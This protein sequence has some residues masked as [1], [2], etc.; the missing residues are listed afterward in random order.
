M[1]IVDKFKALS[2]ESRF[3]IYQMLLRKNLAVEDIADV[4]KLKPITVR[5]HISELERSG[6]ITK[7]NLRIGFAGR[8]KIVYGVN[9]GALDI[10]LTGKNYLEL[11][12]TFFNSVDKYFK[13]KS[14]ITD[15]YVFLGRQLARNFLKDFENS[16]ISSWGLNQIKEEI[17]CKGLQNY[18]PQPEMIEEDDKHFTFRIY[19]CPF[20]ETSL[21]LFE[22]ICNKLSS[23]YVP[24][25]ARLIGAVTLEALHR[26]T[27]TEPYCE[28]KVSFNQ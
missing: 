24:E 10:S 2:C 13:G 9:P 4:T 19:S 8:P 23:A 18:G 6:L 16:N 5:H 27:K 26:R 25:L 11:Q 28:F 1:S 7:S 22:P 3:K 20:L 17:F 15:F 14:E 12:E 21:T